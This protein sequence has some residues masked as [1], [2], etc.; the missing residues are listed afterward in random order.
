MPLLPQPTLPPPCNR[1]YHRHRHHNCHC[2]RYP[3]QFPPQLLLPLLPVT[4]TATVTVT[5]TATTTAL[6]TTIIL[7]PQVKKNPVKLFEATAIAHGQHIN[8][9][10]HFVY[11]KCEYRNQIDLAVSLNHDIMTS[12]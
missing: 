1:H 10:K 3:P 7:T 6:A 5:D 12:F 8:V 9:L 2:H 4:L 11:V